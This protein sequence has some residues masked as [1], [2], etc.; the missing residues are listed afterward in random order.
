MATSKSPN[1]MDMANCVANVRAAR[2]HVHCITNSVA[3]HFTANVLLAAGLTP[4][5]TIAADEVASFVK[6]ADA[7]LINL[8][9]MDAERA[10]A[11]DLALDA[12]GEAE[13]PWALDPVFVQA[14][15]A[16]LNLARQLLNRGPT[17]V[18]CNA[19]EGAALFGDDFAAD[20]NQC[21][22]RAGTIIALT[23][24]TDVIADANRLITLSNGARTM[25]RI[26]AMGCALNALMA[27]F[28]AVEPDPLLAA[29]SAIA[30]FTIAGERSETQSAGPGTFVPVFLDALARLGE[31][32]L[33]NKVNL[34]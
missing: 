12:A 14:S 8:G 27:G 18:R 15:P 11:I 10:R 22:S 5:M 1:G 6:M 29:S 23:G 19:G 4:S 31:E 25:D 30:L 20:L 9:T 26:T 33:A 34:S 3:Q 17:I 24:K 13:K 32:T 28:A 21:A 16:R 7:L 2:P